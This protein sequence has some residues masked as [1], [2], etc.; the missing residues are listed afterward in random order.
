MNGRKT[1]KIRILCRPC[2]DEAEEEYR[3][4][5]ILHIPK[6]RIS[7]NQKLEMQYINGLIPFY[8]INPIHPTYGEIFNG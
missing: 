1:G 3:L 7:H 6:K 4:L 5:G 8:S 2:H